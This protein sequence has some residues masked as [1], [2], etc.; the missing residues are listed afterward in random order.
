MPLR[1]RERELATRLFS[2]SLQ[3]NTTSCT[4]PSE[5]FNASVWQVGAVRLHLVSSL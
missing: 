3:L 4:L 1:E 5:F 2:R